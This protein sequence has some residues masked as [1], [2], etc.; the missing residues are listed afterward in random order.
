[1]LNSVRPFVRSSVRPSHY[2]DL[3][4]RKGIKGPRR[5]LKVLEGS[6]GFQ[7]VQGGSIR[8]KKVQKGSRRFNKAQ[9]G[10]KRLKYKG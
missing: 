3:C 7:K 10:L 6:I 8:L 1:M 9:E 4:A 5:C 2:F